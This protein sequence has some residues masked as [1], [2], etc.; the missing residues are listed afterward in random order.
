MSG[1][2]SI[3]GVALLG[4]GLYL[5]V[6]QIKIFMAGKQDQLGW[7]IRGLGTGIISIMI[8]VYLIVKYL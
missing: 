5:T 3:G 8:G 7:D 2:Y 1:L 6:K 4:V